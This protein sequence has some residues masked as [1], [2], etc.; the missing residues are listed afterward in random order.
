MLLLRIPS[1]ALFLSACSI[2]TNTISQDKL[3]CGSDVDPD[4]PSL[5][6]LDSRQEKIQGNSIE[7]KP[8]QSAVGSRPLVTERGCLSGQGQGSWLAVNTLRNEAVII[9]LPADLQEKKSISMKPIAGMLARPV[10]PAETFFGPTVDLNSFVDGN[11][12]AASLLSYRLNSSSAQNES[13]PWLSLSGQ[14]ALTT[15]R[16]RLAEGRY[17]MEVK[18][19]NVAN[20][21]VLTKTCPVSLDYKIPDVYPTFIDQSSLTYLGQ[22]IYELESDKD[23]RFEVN[24]PTLKTSSYC[25]VKRGDLDKGRVEAENQND[26]CR[27]LNTVTAGNSLAVP[28]RIGFWDLYYKHRDASGNE[29]SLTGPLTVLFKQSSIRSR[30]LDLAK[31]SASRLESKDPRQQNEGTI[32]SLAALRLY[33]ELPTELEKDQL[34]SLIRLILLRSISLDSRPEIIETNM[35]PYRAPVCFLPLSDGEHLVVRNGQETDESYILKADGNRFRIQPLPQETA[36]PWCDSTPDG[37]HFVIRGYRGGLITVGSKENEEWKIDTIDIQRTI[38]VSALSFDGQEFTFISDEGVLRTIQ[39]RDETVSPKETTIPHFSTNKAYAILPSEKILALQTEDGLEL[40]SYE[41]EFKEIRKIF[42]KKH[43]PY[44][45]WEEAYFTFLGN[46]S[47]F[48]FSDTEI[49]GSASRFFAYDVDPEGQESSYRIDLLTFDS[50]ID[51]EKVTAKRKDLNYFYMMDK[52]GD[53]VRY[54]RRN[55]ARNHLNIS[56]QNINP[57][58]S[59]YPMAQFYDRWRKEII[60]LNISRNPEGKPGATV[61]I[62]DDKGT[63]I[64]RKSQMFFDCPSLYYRSALSADGNY[65]AISCKRKFLLLK[66][67][68]DAFEIFREV[69]KDFEFTA[70]HFLPFDRVVVGSKNGRIFTFDLHLNEIP[71]LSTRLPEDNEIRNFAYSES[72]HQL[73]IASTSHTLENGKLYAWNLVDPSRSPSPLPRPNSA[74]DELV[75]NPSKT[76][77]WVSTDRFEDPNVWAFNSSNLQSRPLQFPGHKDQ[78]NDIGFLEGSGLLVSTSHVEYLLIR[79]MNFPDVSPVRLSTFGRQLLRMVTLDSDRFAVLDLE[80]EDLRVY[81]IPKVTDLRTDIC[82]FVSRYLKQTAGTALDRKEHKDARVTCQ[83]L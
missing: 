32:D 74:P 11:L 68:S 44:I 7:L 69:S 33:N 50:Y 22:R 23:L 45:D 37:K 12:S 81:T 71:E 53:L 15:F 80:S 72:T 36:G 52:Y 1:V 79:D 47:T 65:L 83:S 3:D 26:S 63:D 2:F 38:E 20:E 61:T 17:D 31:Q 18:I 5:M 64:I 77:L 42:P 43:I 30:I 70:S 29:S 75:W 19:R 76:E 57:A 6:L 40:F 25:W 67:K 66:R 62:L 58:E 60:K 73:F 16:E 4:A 21:E 82:D 55:F 78:L 48:V 34:A 49:E 51:P 9:H 13:S 8:L 41:D 10:C 54:K 27:D 28:E 39:L 35:N 59:V 56:S 14:P 46:S 24:D